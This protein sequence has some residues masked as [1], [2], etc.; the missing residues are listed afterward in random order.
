MRHHRKKLR[1]ALREYRHVLIVELNHHRSCSHRKLWQRRNALHGI[2]EFLEVEHSVTLQ[3]IQ[4]YCDEH[5]H[6]HRWKSLLVSEAF[7]LHENIGLAFTTAINRTKVSE[8]LALQKNGLDVSF[9][10]RKACFGGELVDYRRFLQ[11]ELRDQFQVHGRFHVNEGSLLRQM[12]EL[13]VNQVIARNCDFELIDSWHIITGQWCET[14]NPVH[15]Q[16]VA[17]T[18]DCAAKTVTLEDCPI[19]DERLGLLSFLEDIE[20]MRCVR[21]NAAPDTAARVTQL[22]SRLPALKKLELEI[23]ET[24]EWVEHALRAAPLLQKVTVQWKPDATRRDVLILDCAAKAVTL[25]D[26]QID[27]E[28]LGLLSF[29]EDIETMRCVRVNAAPNTAARVPQLFSRLHALKELKLEL[30][31]FETVEWVEHALRAAPLLQK[32]TVQ[33]KPDAYVRRVALILNGAAKAVHIEGCQIDDERLAF[34]FLESI[35]T[36]RCVRVNAAPDTAARVTQL[37]SRLPA[38]KA[39]ELEIYDNVEWVEHALR[40]A[41]LLRKVTV[42]FCWQA[43]LKFPHRRL[44]DIM[45]SCSAALIIRSCSKA[46]VHVLCAG[47]EGSV[48]L[49]DFTISQNNGY[50]DKT[51]AAAI[52]E[53]LQRNSSLVRFALDVN[54]TATAQ[55]AAE[56]VLAYVRSLRRHASLKILSLNLGRYNFNRVNSSISGE[57]VKFL[58]HGNTTLQQIEGLTYES[59]EDEHRIRRHLLLNRYRADFVENATSSVPLEDWGDVLMRIGTEECN[60][61]VTELAKRAVEGHA[62][63]RTTSSSPRQATKINICAQDEPPPWMLLFLTTLLVLVHFYLKQRGWFIADPIS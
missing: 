59:V 26:C 6:D 20:T 21:V 34:L 49:T 1:A 38:L 62:R 16:R 42:G 22:F 37:F 41:P 61:F 30:K 15:A 2:A 12:T 44:L 55:Q 14:P 56:I 25:E 47:L 53:S 36:M 35:E 9:R 45:G 48:S 10:V 46:C 13:E 58:C 43:S 60:Y 29:L 31:S 52:L 23:Y 33:W 18:L 24:V 8:V 54:L 63:R 51:D 40:A 19:D 17:L 27:D 32:V 5:P 3:C 39:L 28:R 57:I 11:D 4:E 7:H 50:Y